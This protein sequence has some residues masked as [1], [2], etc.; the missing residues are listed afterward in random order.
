MADATFDGDTLIVTFPA[1]Q[2]EVG[3]EG[4]L[5]SAWKNWFK[6]GTNAK[7]APAF[8]TVGGDP[9]TASGVVS[10]F[11][12]LRNDLGWRIRPAEE[13]ANVTIVGNLYGRDPA[14]PILAPTQGSYTVLV[15]IERDASSVVETAG[16]GVTEQDKLD[17]ADAVWIETL[18]GPRTAKELLR[19]L[20]AVLGGKLSGAGTDTITIRDLADEQDRVVATVDD[21]GNRLAVN[22]IW[23][24]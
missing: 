6:T 2:A 15:T 11:F 8:D 3:A 20:A 17:I 10:P 14:L 12:F 4:E 22:I 16:S 23:T 7:Y 1:S 21:K 9:T 24:D 5:Y 13:D 19:L 18:E